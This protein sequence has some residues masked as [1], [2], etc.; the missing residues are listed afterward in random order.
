MTAAAVVGLVIGVAL[1]VYTLTG[2]AD[3]GG[4]VWDLLARGPRAARQRHLIAT[5]IAPI[6]EANH[7][8]MILVVVLL[9]VCFPPAFAVLSVALHIPVTI[10]L[11][12]IVLRGAAFTFRAYG[13]VTSAGERG[14]GQVF[15]I[16]SVITPIMLGISVGAVVSGNIR[17]DPGTGVVTSG[18]VTPWLA[19]FPIALGGLFLAICALLAATYLAVEAEDAALQD[20]FRVRALGAAV[21]VFGLA[22]GALWLSRAGAPHIFAALTASR[23]ALPVQVGTGLAALAAVAALWRRQ[24]R[25]ARLLVAAQVVG[26]FAGWGVAQW[27]YIVIPDLTL[28][29]SA[30]PEGVLWSTLAVL[31]AGS[32]LLLPALIWLFRVFKAP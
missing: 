31:A 28:A 18:F 26:I 11:V 10:M 21:A 29:Q 2:G 19:P 3:F 25:W 30:A 13:M 8:W 22:F 6:W 32:V 5:A 27:P 16:S 12:G 23:W 20:D 4:G 1:L 15:A 14:W 7:V 17:L 9:F 24:Y